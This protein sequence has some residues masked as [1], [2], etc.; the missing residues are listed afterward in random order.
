MK[1]TEYGGY[2]QYPVVLPESAILEHNGI[3]FKHIKCEH[4]PLSTIQ[5]HDNESIADHEFNNTIQEFCSG[6]ENPK[7]RTTD[8]IIKFNAEHAELAM[9]ERQFSPCHYNAQTLTFEQ[10]IP[11]KKSYSSLEMR[12]SRTRIQMPDTRKSN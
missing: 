3:R 1:I 7:V 9:P 4:F 11:I 2:A 8:D 6:F 5:H 10:H 12:C